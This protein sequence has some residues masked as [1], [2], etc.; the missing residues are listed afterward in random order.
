VE[1]DYPD[2]VGSIPEP[3]YLWGFNERLRM[4]QEK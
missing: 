4:D 1:R 3:L 2:I